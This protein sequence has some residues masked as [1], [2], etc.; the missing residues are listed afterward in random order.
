[1]SWS[2]LHCSCYES[3]IPLERF[4]WDVFQLSERLAARQ[5]T[6]HTG[7]NTAGLVLQPKGRNPC[8]AQHLLT[9]VPVH[10]EE[11]TLGGNVEKQKAMR[12]D[13]ETKKAELLPRHPLS[14]VR[15][16]LDYSRWYWMPEWETLSVVIRQ[17]EDTFTYNFWL[18][19]EPKNLQIKTNDKILF[20]GNWE[21]PDSLQSTEENCSL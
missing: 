15:V 16:R 10:Q 17:R 6:Q 12:T 19:M 20:S 14:R 8:S 4:L 7:E 11:M 5:R 18:K 21:K 2:F 1:M 13:R 3:V 9:I